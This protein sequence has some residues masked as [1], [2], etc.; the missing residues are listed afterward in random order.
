MHKKDKQRAADA[1]STVYNGNSTSLLEGRGNVSSIT[2]SNSGGANRNVTPVSSQSVTP[3]IPTRPAPPP[4][5]SSD[6]SDPLAFFNTP[7]NT[8]TTVNSSS[9]RHP[10]L[11]L[12]SSTLLPSSL[13][14]A[15]Q[16]GAQSATSA[17][18]QIEADK[19]EVTNI[20]ANYAVEPLEMLHLVDRWLQQLLSEFLQQ[21]DHFKHKLGEKWQNHELTN[22][23]YDN[24]DRIR[25]I[26]GAYKELEKARDTILSTESFQELNNYLQKID[27]NARDEMKEKFNILVQQYVKILQCLEFVDKETKASASNNY[28]YDIKKN[29]LKLKELNDKQSY[30]ICIV[31]LEKAG[32]STF[33][34]ALLGYELL[35]TAC[36]RCTQIRTVLKPPLENGDPQLFAAVKF[37]DDQ[38]FHLFFDKMTKKTDENLQELQQR[39]EQVIQKREMLKAKFPEEH[40]RISSLNDANRERMAII[41]HLHDYITGELYVNIIK[42]IAIYTDKLPGKNYELLDVPGF[43]SPIKEHR[44]AGLQ[45]IKTADAF[46]FLTNGQQPSLTEPQ[47]CLLHEI[48]QNHFE[49]MQ[50]AF[51]II[52]KLDLCQTP[53]IYQE[54]YEKASTELIDKHF[55]PE[56]IYAACPRMQTVDKNSEE[57]RLINH[58]LHS[59]GDDLEQ[60]F[61]RSKNGLNKFIEF[62]LPKTHLKQLVDLGRM[63]LVRHVL[64]R[65]DTIKQNQLWSQNLAMTS[66]DEYIKQHNTENWD[67]IFYENIFQP[68][69]AKANHWHTTIVTKERTKFVDN[70][71]QK[72]HD[73]F[74]DL[75]EEFRKRTY[76]IER[77]MFEAH[78]YSK[79]QLNS[80][81]TD[82][83]LRERLSIELEE[84]VGQT[85]N[86]LAEYFYHQYIYELENILNDICPQLKD[87]YRTKLTLEQCT[88]ETH[89][90]VLR[91]CRPMIMATLR[92][93]YLDL[94]VKQDAI[95][96]LIYIAPTV[97][98]NI[99]NIPDKNGEGG[100]LA[101]YFFLQARSSNSKQSSVDAFSQHYAQ[102]NCNISNE[103]QYIGLRILTNV[104]ELE[105]ESIQLLRTVA[106]KLVEFGLYN[107]AEN[108]FRYIKNL[109]SEEP[110][111]FRD[112]ALLLQES[113][114]E[115]K[116]LVEISDL[117]TNDTDLDLHVIEPTG[118][119]CY[120]SHKD[121][122]ISGMISRDFTQG[123]GPEEYFVRKVVKGTYIVRAKYFANHQQSLTGTRTIMSSNQEMI[124]VCKVNFND[125]IQQISNNTVTNNQN[126]NTNIHLYVTCDGC[127]MSPIKEDRYKCLF[128]PDIDLCQSCKSISRTN[129]NSNHQYNHPLLCIKDSSEYPKSVYLNNHN[130][131]NH[132]NNQRNSCFMKPLIG[133]RYKCTCGINLCEK[134][135]FMGLHNTEHRRTKIVKSE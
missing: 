109:R 57:F 98:F 119:E 54:H 73:S 104:L 65:L 123:Y 83:E 64:E 81:P 87:L 51:G 115:T 68:T 18:D 86:I 67:K 31:G 77:L 32:K 38:E 58:K 46:L 94:P 99:A 103:Y 112:L 11:T 79:L 84:I 9:I 122:V 76:P 116:N 129:H 69:F 43:D 90:L 102:S 24:H 63:R 107:L 5:R 52:T 85:S 8:A 59:F 96:E 118:E 44:D 124:D 15:Y 37:Y 80:H 72:F 12:S 101:S 62:E 2:P 61:T 36:E 30:T 45:A 93:S 71:K 33:I 48:Q 29:I 56:R 26:Y 13:Q 111:S 126:L 132:K 55:K 121:T 4:P 75:T 130:K 20:I 22:I 25:K 89:A 113:N 21:R 74:L 120:Y 100:T 127:D 42:E 92:Y 128:C 39:K 135:E 114:S 35:P 3:I 108:I 134:C 97:A 6:T 47:I 131:I 41:K 66:I 91:V 82:N 53:T 19:M 49:A 95:N 7:V 88:H 34:N 50:R 16:R 78:C 105:L 133:I 10:K 1:T 14:L 28:I 60:G 106:Y 70:V 23:K 27:H 125:D 110:Q 17:A 117:Y 40:F